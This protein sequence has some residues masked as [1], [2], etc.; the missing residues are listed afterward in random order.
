MHYS[1]VWRWLL[2]H[3][4]FFI[5]SLLNAEAF[6]VCPST[7]YLVQGDEA[8]IY[9][10]NLAS[11]SYELLS[12]SMGT[13]GKL[14]AIGFNIHDRFMY[15]YSTEFRSL[16][17]I[18]SEFKINVL[19]AS[20]QPSVNFYVGDISLSENAYYLYM[21][22]SAYGLF[23]VAL[24]SNEQNYMV[25][26]RI[27][28]GGTLSLRIFD[29]AFHPENGLLYSVDA[30]G[31]LYAINPQSGATQM[32]G[33]VGESGTFGA[34]YFDRSGNFY[35]SRNTDG[36]IFR[37]DVSAAKPHADF[38][39]F[40][41]ASSNN[42]GARCARSD[43][44][45]DEASLDFGDAP[46]SYGVTLADNGAR[47]EFSETVIL[48]D[49]WGGVDD[50][51]T[52]LSAVQRNTPSVVV[53]RVKGQGYLNAWIDFDQNGQF[54]D[55]EKV[56]TD[57]NVQDGANLV[58]VDIPENAAL[59]D[60]WARFR[61]ASQTGV[62]P[63][64]GVADGE[65]E[66]YSIRLDDEGI[67]VYS[68]PS[69]TGLATVAFED[70]WP[71]IGDYDMNDIVLSLRTH[72][73]VDVNNRVSRFDVEGQLLAVGADYANGLAIQL[74]DIATGNID[75]GAS[76]LFINGYEQAISPL[77]DN[78]PSDDAVFII[79]NN[80]KQYFENDSAC[81]FHRTLEN[82]LSFEASKTFN[83][84]LVLSL[85]NPQSVESAPKDLLN[86]F[87][88]ATP[89]HYHGDAFSEQ[90]GRGLEIHLKNSR[91]SARFNHSFW[92]MADDASNDENQFVTAKGMPWALRVP[93]IWNHP[94]E[95]VDIS[96]AYPNFF[97]FVTTAGA[98]S[99]TWYLSSQS[100]AQLTVDNSEALLP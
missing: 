44:V 24:D 86:P 26:D 27:V 100:N 29:F 48:G 73:F 38:F 82:C 33:N 5:A 92:G 3:M 19:S 68:F 31:E 93:N 9:G 96:R 60:T 69:S 30:D 54:G 22:G 35:I 57:Q 34:A 43:I 85:I 37:I 74:D 16:V 11:G 21:R 52:F 78:A 84:R 94:R 49:R 72:R 62:G 12:D 32:L 89:G 4:L 63:N 77:E 81:Q 80:I 36:F 25:F 98:E 39:A 23:R 20:Q 65:V 83:F 66:D 61:I 67:S 75:I 55:G 51:V 46:T 1:V 87:I 18:D 64:G 10:V 76:R 70:N 53:A 28:D 47:H 90:P 88:F 40:G 7:A 99:A 41:P 59:G 2:G 58:L 14:N 79:E 13:N 91:V 17:R 50:G 95:R 45:N 71:Q 97:E 6:D 56:C 42:D 8:R 15:G